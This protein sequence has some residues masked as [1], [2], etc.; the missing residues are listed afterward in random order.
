MDNPLVKANS[1]LFRQV[2][3]VREWHKLPRPLALLNLRAFRD[4]LRE[5]NLYGTD[6]P[7]EPNGGNGAVAIEEVPKYRTYDGSMNDPA[8]PDMGRA[9]T[10]FAAHGT[11][12]LL[13]SR[14]RCQTDFSTKTLAGAV[15]I[16]RACR[17]RPRARP[18]A[19]ST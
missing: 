13:R 11:F 10:R 1:L 8:F 19:G 17:C 3:K 18:L 14:V 2:N 16:A 4:E 9:G 5:M 6:A 12:F 15:A 7:P